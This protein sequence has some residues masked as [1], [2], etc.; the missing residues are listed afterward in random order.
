MLEI[1]LLPYPSQAK[2][3]REQETGTGFCHSER[4]DAKYTK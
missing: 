1:W 2:K 4:S 3:N